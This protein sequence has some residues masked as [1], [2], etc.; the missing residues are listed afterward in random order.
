[1]MLYY[2]NGQ[3]WVYAECMP[4][5][6][7]FASEVAGGDEIN[8]LLHWTETRLF[9]LHRNVYDAIHGLQLSGETVYGAFFDKTLQ[10]VRKALLLPEVDKYLLIQCLGMWG[11]A[12][13]QSHESGVPLSDL[14]QVDTT[15]A[16]FDV[17]E[18]IDDGDEFSIRTLD[19]IV[20]AMAES[21]Y[22]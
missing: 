8:E 14:P 5:V 17:L 20:R 15:D 3:I 19:I 11:V 21:L 2:V 1:M 4:E 13:M 9:E 22:Q 18:Q 10:I 6:E 12:I 16:V 7:T